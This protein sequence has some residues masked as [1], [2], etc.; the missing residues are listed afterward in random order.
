VHH[1]AADTFN[2]SVATITRHLCARTFGRV[3]ENQIAGLQVMKR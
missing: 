1:D 3:S 2:A